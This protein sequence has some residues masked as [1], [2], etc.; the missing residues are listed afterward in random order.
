MVDDEN[1]RKVAGEAIYYGPGKCPP[2]TMRWEDR[3]P[4]STGSL[5]PAV[6]EQKRAIVRPQNFYSIPHD[7]DFNIGCEPDKTHENSGLY[8][9]D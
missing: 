2:G 8:R 7:R 9:L 1:I 4:I 5:P 6:A 3:S